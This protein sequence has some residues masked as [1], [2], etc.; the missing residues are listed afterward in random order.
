MTEVAEGAGN[1]H[2]PTIV[3]ENNPAA[4]SAALEAALASYEANE[5]QRQINAAETRVAKAQAAL[6]AALVTLASVRAEFGG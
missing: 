1:A 2:A 4:L 5:P 6:D 3:V